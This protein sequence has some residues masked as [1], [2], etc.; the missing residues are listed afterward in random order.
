MSNTASPGG[1]TQLDREDY[2]DGYHLNAIGAKIFTDH[3]AEQL[4]NLA[5]DRTN[6]A[7]P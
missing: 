2:A 6:P 7:T 5:H 3:L 1:P 4:R